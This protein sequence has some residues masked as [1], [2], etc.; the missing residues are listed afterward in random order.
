AV[1]W[2]SSFAA[3]TGYSGSSLAF[4]LGLDARG[5]SVR[6]LFLYGADHDEQVMMGQMHPHIVQLQG[7]P[8][9]LDVPQVVYAPADRFSKNSG[10]YRIG[11]TMLEVDRLPTSWVEQANQMDEVWTPTSWGTDV[12]RASGVHR[13][14]YVI[15]LGV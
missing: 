9:R 12:F 6:P 14:L 11:F 10:A 13:P 4:V 2:H 3:L 8:L 7:L 1:V 15:P 5:T